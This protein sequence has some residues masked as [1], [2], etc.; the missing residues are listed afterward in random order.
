MPT[1][2][3]CAASRLHRPATGHPVS[4]PAAAQQARPLQ[5]DAR[6]AVNRDRSRN[7][8]RN[9]RHRRLSVSPLAPDPRLGSARRSFFERGAAPVGAVPEAILHSW[10]RCQRHGL[11]VDAQPAAEPLTDNRLRE[12]RQ[13]RERLWRQARP[14]LDGLAAEMT[15]SGSIVLLT[16]EDG[17]ILDAEGSAGFL[18]KA[19]RV[20]LMPGMRW[21]EGTVGTQRDRHRAGRRARAAGAWR[22]ALLRPARHP[23]LFGRADPGSLR[24][25]PGLCSMSQIEHR[26]FADGL[27][28]CELLRLHHQP[29]LLGSAREGVLGFRSGRLVAANRA[30][31]ALF[32]LDRQ[33]IGRTPYEAL[34]EQPLSRLAD[35]G[36]LLDR[37]GRRLYG[38][39]EA[40]AS[41]RSVATHG[42]TAP[43][44]ARAQ[45]HCSIPGSNSSWP[46]QDACFRPGCRCCCRARPAPA[47]KSSRRELHA[48][49][50]RAGKPFVAVNC[51]AL[52][53]GL[54]EA[55][56]AAG[57]LRQA[58]GG[59]LFLDE[60]GDMPLAL[61]PRLL[62]VLQERELSPLGGGKPVK[63]DFALVC[64]SHCELPQAVDAGRF[65]ADLYYRIAD[66]VVTLAPLRQHPDRAALV[67]ALWQQLGQ[68]HALSA[69]TRAALAAHAWP[70][71]LR[72][73]SACL[74]TLAALAEPGQP[75]G[76]Q[77]LPADVRA[78]T[79]IAPAVACQRGIGG[80]RRGGHAPGAG[81]MPGQRQRGRQAAGHQPQH[82][83]PPAGHATRLSGCAGA[84]PVPRAPAAA[85]ESAR[86]HRGLA[87]QALDAV[88]I[89][90]LHQRGGGQPRTAHAQHVGQMQE[91]AG[92]LRTDATGRAEAHA[93]D[94]L[95]TGGHAGQVGQIGITRGGIQL[96]GRPGRHRKAAAGL[97]H[98]LHLRG[99]E[100]GACTNHRI[101]HGSTIAL[102][103]SSARGVR[104]V[105]SINGRPPRNS[106]LRDLH[107]IVNVIGG[108]H[109][110]HRCQF[111]YRTNAWI[112][113][114]HRIAPRPP[115]PNT[116]A[117]LT[118]L[119]SPGMECFRPPAAR[120]KRTVASASKADRMPCRMPAAKAS[121]PPMRSTMPCSWRTGACARVPSRPAAARPARGGPRQRLPLGAG[122]PLQLR[123]C[124]ECAAAAAS[125]RAITSACSK[126]CRG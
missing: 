29:A 6:C 42:P 117:S 24:A 34:F 70:G 15:H 3:C 106:A 119:K 71:N 59:T 105:T 75:V 23:H 91:L 126:R 114:G 62:R 7:N 90:G 104:R 54:I 118:G 8:C 78:G 94:Q 74:R 100:H 1:L 27:A 82:P 26:G 30:G 55:E 60:I 99:I 115:G 61:Q 37:Q 36:V 95:R 32:G 53:E 111:Q 89:A 38:V 52:P 68:G 63:L 21:D 101:R 51:A 9:V 28:D 39:R 18:D 48:R 96:G 41:R 120:P 123:E 17:W 86:Q 69:Q 81:R 20:A 14:E 98:R 10:Q 83:V 84:G 50:T 109:R 47:R 72:Q 13:R 79:S 125:T 2:A 56:L 45:A 16:D 4:R 87:C 102:M 93:D 73:L 108:E 40:R 11:R 121:P 97:F 110:N 31:L 43:L 44:P 77:L 112:S 76:P 124:V 64:A 19:G 80:D 12:L 5:V 113:A 25:M 46:P 66:H 65:R 92:G 116:S 22:R 67:D 103:A 122:Q 85:E 107:R 33:D 35:D 49:S 57:L 58:E 88:P